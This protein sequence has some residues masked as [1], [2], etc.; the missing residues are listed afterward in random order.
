MRWGRISIYLALLLSGSACAAPYQWGN[1]AIGGG[2]FVSGLVTSKSEPGLVYARTDVGGAYRWNAKA[3]RWTPLTDWVSDRDTGL[4][5]IESIA[6]DPKAPGKLYMLAGTAYLNGGQ[7]AIL[8]SSD[9][10][11]TF[12]RIDVSAQFKAHGNGMGRN[13]GEKLQVDPA[14]GNILF[15]GTRANGLFKSTDEGLSWRH[16]DALD[17][18]TTPN[19]NGISFVLL[20]PASVAKGAAQRIVVGVSRTGAN[21]Y[22]STD[23]GGSFAPVRGAPAQLLPQRAVL[24]GGDLIVTYGN[25]AGPWGKPAD[26]EPMDQGQVWK[27]RLAS[28]TWTNITPPLNRAYAGVTVD[29]ANPARLAV[30]TINYFARQYGKAQGDRIFLSKDGGAS[31]TDVIAKGFVLDPQSI[32]WI[33]GNSIHWAASIEFDPANPRAAMVVSGNG[34][35]R[36]GDIE[37]TP[38]TWAFHVAG[39]EETVPLGLVSIPQGPLI[40]V[41]GDYDGFVHGDVRHYPAIVKP[42]MGTTTGL[43]YAARNSKVVARV[44]SAIYLS[45]DMGKSWSRTAAMQGQKGQ[46]ALNATGE[47]LLHS[48]ENSSDSFVSRN[49][50]ARWDKVEGL[51]VRNAYP[52]ADPVD[53]KRFYALDGDHLLVSKDAGASFISAGQLPGANGSKLIRAAPEREGDLWV[54][55]YDG[56]LVR[57]TD[58]GKHFTPLRNVSY[59][60]AVGFGKA[61]TDSAYPTV[62]LWGTVG[63]VRGMFCSTDSGASWTRVNDDQHQY[64]GPGNGQFVVGDMNRPGV[65]Y[66]STAGRGLVAGTSSSGQPCR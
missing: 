3:A 37:A 21:L 4:L 2:G 26:A 43:A 33:D 57:S 25:G 63:S 9:Y 14:S 7:S 64:G 6:L 35:F 11:K 61:A 22:L 16:L 19:G 62:Y 54:A 15:V 38:V 13:S 40:S 29:P 32:S 28:G 27:Y 18:R 59:G 31:W 65:V 58:G 66:M 41:I 46:L 45:R 47:V 49:G 20:D 53:P 5:G 60:G 1:V 10:G 39:L 17:V 51:H 30:T 24:A 48:P 12:T 52:L 8:K 36:T 56:G 44:G 34:I 55:L 50:G 23:G 42:T